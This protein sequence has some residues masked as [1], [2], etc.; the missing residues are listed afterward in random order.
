MITNK[1]KK[2]IENILY[3][4]KNIDFKIESLNIHINALSNDIH[5]FDGSLN[6]EQLRA[7]RNKIIDLKEVV[8]KAINDL[9]DEEYKIIELRYLQRGKMTWFEIGSLV[10]FEK[11]YLCKKNKKIL[12]KI[13]QFL[14]SF[15]P[16][17]NAQIMVQ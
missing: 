9:S 3:K 15:L 17:F 16:L 6:I 8:N 10:G 7:E 11:D 1:R 12:N 2:E 4:Y 5:I 13:G 14:D